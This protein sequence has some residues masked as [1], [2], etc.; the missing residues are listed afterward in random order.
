MLGKISINRTFCATDKSQRL[1]NKTASKFA[2]IK[3]S[4]EFSKKLNENYLESTIH[5]SK[6][7]ESPGFIDYKTGK[8]TMPF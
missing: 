1:K 2:E 7:S 8:T 3:K 5:Q 6:P 4:L